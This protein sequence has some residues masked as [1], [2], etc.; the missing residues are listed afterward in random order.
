SK[1]QMLFFCHSEARP[2]GRGRRIKRC[3]ICYVYG[4]RLDSSVVQDDKKIKFLVFNLYF[5][6]FKNY[7]SRL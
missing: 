4:Y 6:V 2:N 7:L 5:L 3:V 1:N